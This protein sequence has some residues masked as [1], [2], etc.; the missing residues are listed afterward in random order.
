MTSLSRPKP[1]AGRLLDLEYE[2]HASDPGLRRHLAE[3]FVDS[4]A[5]VTSPVRFDVTLDDPSV[6]TLSQ[7]GDELASGLPGWVLSMLFW[8]V[9]RAVVERSTG[10][11]LH[12]GAVA[13]R[14]GRSIWVVG[15]SGA[16]KSTTTLALARAGWRLLT[17]D[18]VAVS[19]DRTCTGSLKPIG[20]RSGSWSLL[21][22]ASEEAPI[23]PAPFALPDTRQCAASAL[24]VNTVSAAGPPELVIFLGAGGAV[25]G[26]IRPLPRSHGV[27][28]LIEACFDPDRY[29]TELLELMASAVRGAQTLEWHRG[30]LDRF[31]DQVRDLLAGRVG[32]SPPGKPDVGREAR[33]VSGVESGRPSR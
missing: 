16:G 26:E 4:R 18:V 3:V 13:D 1:I 2:I 31:D 19:A 9:N 12:A 23:P 17:D 8:H 6:A 15:E 11:L 32:M 24:G 27:V 20:V 10:P 21:G 14:A 29:G 5:P 25:P 33:S 30:P 22:I 28:R 7:D